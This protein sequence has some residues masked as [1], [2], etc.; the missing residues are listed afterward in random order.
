MSYKGLDE[1]KQCHRQFIDYI[2]RSFSVIADV[3]KIELPVSEI[4]YIYDIIHLRIN[5][6]EV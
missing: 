4:A 1:F 6:L 3:Y 2:E 5:D